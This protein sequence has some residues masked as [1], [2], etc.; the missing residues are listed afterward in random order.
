M[1]AGQSIHMVDPTEEMLRDLPNALKQHPDLT[2]V[3]IESSNWKQR[4]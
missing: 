3:L 2:E 4:G 1:D